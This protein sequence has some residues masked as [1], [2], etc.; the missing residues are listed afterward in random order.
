MGRWGD[1]KQRDKE[2]TSEREG[3]GE[4]VGIKPRGDNDTLSQ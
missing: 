3:E 2:I 1:C 4:M